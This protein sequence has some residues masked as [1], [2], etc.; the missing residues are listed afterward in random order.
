MQF[1]DFTDVTPS[2]SATGWYT[3]DL[4]AYIPTGSTGVA[5]LLENRDT[6]SHAY[7][8]RKPGDTTDLENSWEPT[9]GG[10][11]LY[12]GVNSSRQVQVYYGSTTYTHTYVVAAFGSE[13][14]FRDTAADVTPGTAGSWQTVDLSGYISEAA[15]AAILVVM[16]SSWVGYAFGARRYGNTGYTRTGKLYGQ[17][18][19][20]ICPL[21]S[22]KRCEVYVSNTALKVYLV[23][24][25]KSGSG[26]TFNDTPT[27]VSLSTA[28]SYIDLA[29]LP[30]GS[31]A[32]LWEVLNTE[33]SLNKKQFLRRNGSA[34]DHYAYVRFW[35]RQY[36][37][38]AV[39]ANR[40]A[41]QE[42]EATTMDAYVWA[43]YVPPAAGIGKLAW[44]LL[45]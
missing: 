9:P 23:G 8:A 7:G 30:S 45:G 36:W 12:A 13:A 42:I 10:S 24:Y 29:A 43:Y 27:D 15:D 44:W 19:G 32:G 40:I 34:V 39:D 33:A 14:A 25:L 2:P 6:S 18:I 1:Y 3:L 4:S 41:E 35:Q 22:S 17:Q 37:M 11:M 5:L 38:C 21:D 28:G 31:T 16:E 26:W 20:C